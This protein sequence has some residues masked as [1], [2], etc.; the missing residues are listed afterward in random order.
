MLAQQPSCVSWISK[1]G[2]TPG[3][4]GSRLVGIDAVAQMWPRLAYS[5]TRPTAAAPGTHP[6]ESPGVIDAMRDG[7]IRPDAVEFPGRGTAPVC[8]SR[9]QPKSEARGSLPS[10]AC[11]SSAMHRHAYLM[12]PRDEP[13]SGSANTANDTS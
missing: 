8:G 1:V 5:Y 2:I 7:G 13:H 3:R 6:L 11:V 12:R 4:M 10:L 9:V